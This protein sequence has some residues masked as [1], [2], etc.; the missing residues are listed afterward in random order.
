MK[1]AARMEIGYVRLY[2]RNRGLG[3]SS[4][5]SLMLYVQSMAIMSREL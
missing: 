4:R 2:S 5:L 3:M 1:T